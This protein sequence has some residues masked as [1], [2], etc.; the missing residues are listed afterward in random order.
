MLNMLR[1]LLLLLALLL[2]GHMLLDGAGGRSQYRTGICVSVSCVPAP[3]GVFESCGAKPFPAPTTSST[4]FRH[5]R[6]ARAP[7]ISLPPPGFCSLPLL[8]IPAELC[9]LELR[10]W[11]GSLGSSST[12]AFALARTS[13]RP[14]FR[15]HVIS[16]LCCLPASWDPIKPNVFL[17]AG[18]A[19]R[20]LLMILR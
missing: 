5:V 19:H 14:E 7:N 15:F 11:Q 4:N 12:L 9:A 1:A 20:R 3:P 8:R 13:E 16:G 10:T 17:A 6:R 2:H 18:R